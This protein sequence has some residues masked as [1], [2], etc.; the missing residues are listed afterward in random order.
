LKKVS[1]S[2]RNYTPG[3]VGLCPLYGINYTKDSIGIKNPSSHG[4]ISVTMDTKVINV[5]MD[6]T[7]IRNNAIK[8]N[9]SG[10]SVHHVQTSKDFKD[11]TDITVMV[12][13]DI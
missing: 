9:K 7:N 11:I 8:A 2:G 12:L 1:R 4:Y 13:M 10:T 5:I 3:V 6:T